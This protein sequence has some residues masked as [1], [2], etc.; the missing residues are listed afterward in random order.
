MMRCHGDHALGS[1]R[2]ADVM[3]TLSQAP[4]DQTL[5]IGEPACEG[6][7]GEPLITDASR[8]L[9][10]EGAMQVGADCGRLLAGHQT[11]SASGVYLSRVPANRLASDHRWGQQELLGPLALMIPVPDLSA[12]LNPANEVR[13]GLVT[14]VHRRDTGSLLKPRSALRASMVKINGP[15]NGVDSYAPFGGE[16]ACGY[17]PGE[18]GTAALS[19]HSSTRTATFARHS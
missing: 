19:I 15:T 7:T 9:L 1:A 13:F 6:A 11:P 12:A 10:P 5:A 18:Q 14:T 2:P 4:A 3:V 8:G 16:G 17:G